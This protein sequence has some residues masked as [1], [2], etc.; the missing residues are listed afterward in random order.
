MWHS[1]LSPLGLLLPT[2]LVPPPSS[3]PS[4]QGRPS[5]FGGPV[6]IM[7]ETADTDREK[8]RCELISSG[9]FC[10]EM[11]WSAHY[12]H[13]V[14]C[15]SQCALSLTRGDHL[16]HPSGPCGHLPLQVPLK[17]LF[18]PLDLLSA[19]ARTLFLVSLRKKYGP[20]PTDPVSPLP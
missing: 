4:S 15:T 9:L 11:C 17:A 19:G 12:T 20:S 3:L 14:L 5:T 6:H 18:L 1:E 7:C 16:R 2:G 13:A 8:R 10:R